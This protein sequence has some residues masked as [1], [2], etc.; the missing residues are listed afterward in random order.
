MGEEVGG[1]PEE[2]RPDPLLVAKRVVGQRVEVV[3]ELGE[4][5]AFRGDVAVVEAVVRRPE[6]LDE[7]ER[8]GHL[9]AGR[10]HRV[11]VRV[12][13]G[14]V[15]RPDPEHVAAVP[16]ERVPE[17]D[18]DPE[19]VGHPRAEDEPV[20]FVDLEGEWVGRVEPAERD[21]A[22]HVGEEVV[23]HVRPPAAIALIGFCM[24]VAQKPPTGQRR[25][26][27]RS[28][29]SSLPALHSAPERVGRTAL[30]SGTPAGG[31][32]AEADA[33]GGGRFHGRVP[34]P[35]RDARDRRSR[36]L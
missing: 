15:E 13:P 24:R 17:A 21:R 12:E 1:A 33:R 34:A 30:T 31:S 32:W 8:D 6:L 36:H 23:G 20:G 25:G 27:S 22:R 4:R 26:R 28:A 9:L 35:H 7:L 10:R 11:G 29:G 3:A 16:R 18:A 19:V 14:P 5:G 2:G